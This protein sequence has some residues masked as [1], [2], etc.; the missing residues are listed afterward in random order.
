LKDSD[1]VIDCIWRLICLHIKKRISK[2]CNGL[3]T[4]KTR[5]EA[6]LSWHSNEFP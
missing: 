2:L 1:V 5:G 4:R 6:A 3:I